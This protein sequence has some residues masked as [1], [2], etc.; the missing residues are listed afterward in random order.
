MLFDNVP[1]MRLILDFHGHM[2]LPWLYL[3][4]ANVAVAARGG[5]KRS[6]NAE[7][8]THART[9]GLQWGVQSPN[10]SP[11]YFDTGSAGAIIYLRSALLVL[12]TRDYQLSQPN[13]HTNHS[14][15]RATRPSIA[16]YLID[17]GKTDYD[18]EKAR[19]ELDILRPSIAQENRIIVL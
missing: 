19:T 10:D 5:Q 11:F 16:S 9:A 14:L 18:A 17:H 6:K 1:F 3:D 13:P 7:H 4:P 12:M 8:S 15:T 2:G